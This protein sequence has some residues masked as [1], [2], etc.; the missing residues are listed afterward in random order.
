MAT[1]ETA[2]GER[3][4]RDASM[5][6]LMAIAQ[7]DGRMDE[8]ESRTLGVLAEEVGA[9]TPPNTPVD[10]DAEL[11]KIRSAEARERVANAAHA[12]ASIDGRCSPREHAVLERIHAAFGRGGEPEIALAEEEWGSRMA[13]ARAAIDRAT[14]EFLHAVAALG[15]APNLA[16]EELVNELNAKKRAA[17]KE[18]VDAP[19]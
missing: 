7:A 18:A 3:A 9:A 15:D 16:Y 8:E 19:A 17:L 1:T 14:A 2:R 5:R 6:V 12:I 13:G 4:E 11:A 10:L